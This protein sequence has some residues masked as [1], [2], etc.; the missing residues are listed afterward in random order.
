MRI[1]VLIPNLHCPRIGDSVSAVLAQEGV[2]DTFEVIV[3]GRDRYHRIP[4]DPRVTFI[5]SDRDL[6]PAEARNVAIRAAR[7]ELFA[8]LDADCVPEPHWMREL[9]SSH[10]QGHPLVAGSLTFDR[11]DFWSL[12]D[13][14]SAHHGALPS[15]PEGI[16]TRHHPPVANLLMEKKVLDEVGVFDERY[17]R[18]QDFE[19]MM[20]IAEAGYTF[21][22]NPRAAAAHRHSRSDAQSFIGHAIAWAPYSVMI[23]RQYADVLKSPWYMRNPWALRVLSPFIAAG[24]SA[25]IW[26]RHPELFQDVHTA[27]AVFLAK[28]VWCWAAA[29]ALDGTIETRL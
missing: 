9:L 1:S 3:V 27:P 5:E 28:L 8:F 20:R 19:L 29:A 6:N 24:V 16:M 2:I 22:F 23:R 7:G 21:Y 26:W 18:G 13:N 15:N 17:F 11:G 10:A 14:I 4:D 12:A 25:R